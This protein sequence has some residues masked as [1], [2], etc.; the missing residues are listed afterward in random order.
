MPTNSASTPT[1]SVSASRTPPNRPSGD[2]GQRG[3]DDR[4]ARRRA[5]GPGRW[6]RGREP[7]RT[8]EI[9]GTRVARRAGTML[10][11]SVTI[12]P[13]SMETMIV[14]VASTVPD[15]GRSTPMRGEQR[16]HA[17][18]DAE[19]RATR[20]ITEATQAD[21]QA[22]EH[23]RAH[24]LAARGAER[25]QRRELPRALGDGD[26]ERVEDHERA[27]EQRDAAEAEQEVRDELQALV[28]VLGVGR[29]LLVAGLD[30]GGAG[31]SGL[32]VLR[33]RGRRDAVAWP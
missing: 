18:G 31:S 8:A 14:R 23:D 10:A 12:V 20:P 13:V 6:R 26:R 1:P 22:F 29:G 15:S 30:L 24:D 4:R 5:C 28:D 17:L 21:D 32:I 19:R 25:A 16:A 33:Q 2:R 11:T 7:S 27:H 3:A 9:G